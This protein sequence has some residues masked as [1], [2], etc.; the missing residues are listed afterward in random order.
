MPRQAEAQVDDRYSS[1]SHDAPG[2]RFE[3][4]LP[5][6]LAALIVAAFLSL[7]STNDSVD[8]AQP[9]AGWF[10]ALLASVR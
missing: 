2:L 10:V 9:P 1:E 5:V 4:S 8:G 7:P 6:A 3:F